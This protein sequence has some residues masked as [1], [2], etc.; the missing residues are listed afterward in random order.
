MLYKLQKF[1]TMVDDNVPK[2]L[3]WSHLDDESINSLQ[4]SFYDPI[5]NTWNDSRQNPNSKQQFLE[6]KIWEKQYIQL[7][8]GPQKT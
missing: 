1:A 4:I 7:Q 6:Q 5:Y 2:T 8:I 3:Y